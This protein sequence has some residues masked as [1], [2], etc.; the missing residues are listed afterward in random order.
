MV[1]S[2]GVKYHDQLAEKWDENY[3]RKSF[4]RRLDCFN[5]ILDHSVIPGQCWLDLGCGSG[6]LSLQ[7]IKRGASVVALDGSP[8]M[9]L[10]ARRSL[11]KNSS[12][13][14]FREGDVLDLSWSLP[15]AFDGVLCSSVIEYVENA[16]E[17]IKEVSRVLKSEGLFIISV[18]PKNS[19]VRGFQ[20]IIRTFFKFLGEDKYAYLE[21]SRFEIAP[22]VVAD[23]LQKAHFRL[24]SISGFD[25]IL[26]AFLF[27]IFRPALLICVAKKFTNNS[28]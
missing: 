13:I 12:L 7:L 25:P 1:I 26:P 9:L 27:K 18:P 19:L 15:S 6:N 3:S 16:N 17:L 21:V 8:S 23:W 24:S 11:D 28:N 4:I 2:Q 14:S 20:K 10:A 22:S 5:L